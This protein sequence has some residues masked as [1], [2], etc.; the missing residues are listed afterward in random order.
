[1]IFNCR[2]KIIIFSNTSKNE[3]VEISNFLENGKEYNFIVILG[4]ESAFEII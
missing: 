2:D 3:K 1:L 4:E